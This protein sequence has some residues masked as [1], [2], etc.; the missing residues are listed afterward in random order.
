MSF[1]TGWKQRIDASKARIKKR[2]ARFRPT[3]PRSVLRSVGRLNFLPGPLTET[4]IGQ[5]GAINPVKK[6]KQKRKI[7]DHLK[8]KSKKK[9]RKILCNTCKCTH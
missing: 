3:V 4:K 2:S 8:L 1:S 9:E 6:T 7:K 5:K